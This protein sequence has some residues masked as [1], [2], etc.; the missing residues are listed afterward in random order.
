MGVEPTD[1]NEGNEEPKAS[2]MERKQIKMRWKPGHVEILDRPPGFVR[3]SRSYV[4]C[5]DEQ[6]I[7]RNSE[8]YVG[9]NV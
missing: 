1:I 4:D 3:Q 5:D 6:L 9:P 8:W 2:R 7:S